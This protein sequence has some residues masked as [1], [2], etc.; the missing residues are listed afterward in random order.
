MEKLTITKL[1]EAIKEKQHPSEIMKLATQMI[2]DM[3]LS[4]REFEILNA[5]YN[6]K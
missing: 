5:I 6:N 3:E 1:K 2:K 4:K